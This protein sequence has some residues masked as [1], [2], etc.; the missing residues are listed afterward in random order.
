MPQI[1]VLSIRTSTSLWPTAGLGT[2]S[3]QM[4]GSG[5]ALTK[6]FMSHTPPPLHAIAPF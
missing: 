6:A 5:L 2:S 1:A 3:I 4:P